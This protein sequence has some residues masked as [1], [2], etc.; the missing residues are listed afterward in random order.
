MT[1]NPCKGRETGCTGK[2]SKGSS[3]CK[4]CATVN[5]ARERSRRAARKLAGECTVCGDPVEVKNGKRLTMC[6]R[7]LGY[8]KDRSAVAR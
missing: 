3:R 4:A 8:Y 5:A 1:A 7:H 2:P 6:Q